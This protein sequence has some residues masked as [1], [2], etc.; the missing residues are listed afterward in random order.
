MALLCTK[1]NDYRVIRLA[2]GKDCMKELTSEPKN[3]EKAKCY[4]K[5]KIIT[6]YDGM[7]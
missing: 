5:T 2:K 3:Y 4:D 7:S 1:C 6:L